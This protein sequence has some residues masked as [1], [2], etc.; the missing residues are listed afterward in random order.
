MKKQLIALLTTTFAVALVPGLALAKGA[1]EAVI[2]G[3][4]LDQPI[5]MAGEGQVGGEELMRL[6]ESAG[7]FQVVFGQTPDVTLAEQPEGAL[8]PRYTITYTMPGPNNEL[9]RLS[10]DL[11]PYATPNPVTYMAPGQPFFTTEQ[12]RGGW[13]VAT[14]Q[15]KDDLVAA[16]LPESAP[17]GAGDGDGFPW[18]ALG[19]FAAALVLVVAAG[20]AIYLRRRERPVRGASAAS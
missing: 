16:G 8:G 13:Y 3:P 20:A 18:T 12:T 1:S 17:T 6:A 9:D 4:G 14:S 15:L 19:A 11:Y 2:I 7:F 10:Q 5:A